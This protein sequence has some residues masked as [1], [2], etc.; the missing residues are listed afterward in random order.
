MLKFDKFTQKNQEAIQKAME[1]AHELSHQQIEPEHLIYAFLK[2]EEDTTSSSGGIVSSILMHFGISPS[3]ILPKLIWHFNEPFANS[4]AI[5][6]YYVCNLARQHVPMVLSGD[7]GDE[8]FAGY[9]R[10]FEGRAAPYVTHLIPN[11]VRRRI[12]SSLVGALRVLRWNTNGAKKNP[13]RSS[14]WKS[15]SIPSAN[16]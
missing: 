5:P 10:H 11:A 4:S 14:P 2:E 12:Q 6:T 16:Y 1:L 9:P 15:G 13:S 3:D 8:I 7:G